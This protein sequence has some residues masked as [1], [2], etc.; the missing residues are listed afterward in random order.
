LC[1]QLGFRIDLKQPGFG[2]REIEAPGQEGGSDGHG[3]AVFQE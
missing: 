2:R 3:V 1:E